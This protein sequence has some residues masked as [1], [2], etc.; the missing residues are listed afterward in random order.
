MSDSAD[1]GPQLERVR[2]REAVRERLRA[3]RSGGGTVGFVPT[4]GALHAGHISLVEQARED[5][6]HVIASLFVNPAQFDRPEDL[7]A[8][9]RDEEG[10]CALLAA[11][12]CD[13][14]WIG[15][16][17]DLYPA[18]F[19]TRVIP[20]GTLV[21]GL[22]GATRPGHFAGVTTIV[23]K[24]FNT[25]APDRAYFG[26]K[27]FQQLAIIRRMVRDLDMPVVVV[28][29]PTVREADGLAMSSRNRNL[30]AAGRERARALSAGLR[31]ASLAWRRGEREA[32]RLLE[33]ARQIIAPAVDRI[34]YLELVDGDSLVPVTGSVDEAAV[35]AVAAFVDGVRLIDNHPPARAFPAAGATSEAGPGRAAGEAPRGSVPHG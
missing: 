13:T 28:P 29:G 5:C 12:G 34:D 1:E 25:V 27:D 20:E 3:A 35:L 9:P 19:S 10:D 30:G 31:A 33:E 6:D 2:T 7:E 22:C 23:T 32:E 8:Y 26:E 15:T 21:Q 18:D 11:A 17:P 24:L 16:T 14:V 4:M